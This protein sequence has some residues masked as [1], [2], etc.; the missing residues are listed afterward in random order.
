MRTEVRP[1][2]QR[3]TIFEKMEILAY[4]E[5]LEAEHKQTWKAIRK[6]KKKAHEKQRRFCRGVNIQKLCEIKFAGKLKGIKI[7]QMKSQC[8]S[9]KWYLLTEHQQRNTFQLSDVQKVALGLQGLV[10]G[11]R[12]LPPDQIAETV[13]AESD[14]KRWQIP[15]KVLEEGLSKMF[16][17][18]MLVSCCF[19]N[20]CTYRDL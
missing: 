7:C 6:S 2:G 19:F 18:Y 10:K 16:M 1:A 17:V 3:L 12:S 8:A 11:W 13:K 14:L 4:A 5:E 20:V 15:G 9:Q